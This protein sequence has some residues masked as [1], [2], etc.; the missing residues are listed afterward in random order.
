MVVRRKNPANLSPYRLD[1]GFYRLLDGKMCFHLARKDSESESSNHLDLNKRAGEGLIRGRVA[2]KQRRKCPI[3]TNVLEI[4]FILVKLSS[5][6]LC[7]KPSQ[8]KQSAQEC[9]F[10]EVG[11][12]AVWG[13][14]GSLHPL[15]RADTRET[16][17][18]ADLTHRLYRRLNTCL[19]KGWLERTDSKPTLVMLAPKPEIFSVILGMVHH[20]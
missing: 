10:P 5:L 18:D 13:N 3:S 19:T 20:G 9:V 15:K 4:R 6:F 8:A 11:G 16:Q 7:L 12:G 2:V 14:T 1:S 17:Q